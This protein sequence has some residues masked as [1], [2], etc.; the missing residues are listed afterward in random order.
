MQRAEKRERSDKGDAWQPRY[1]KKLGAGEAS[2]LPGECP[3]ESV[4]FY[5]WSGEGF[6]RDRRPVEKP[7]GSL[8]PP[9]AG[10]LAGWLAGAECASAC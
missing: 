8:A 2:A 4:P 1:F 7:G 6:N 9:A 10:W 5:Q 3:A